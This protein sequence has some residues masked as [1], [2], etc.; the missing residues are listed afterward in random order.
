MSAAT[1]PQPPIHD[2]DEP[3]PLECPTC[4]TRHPWVWWEPDASRWPSLPAAMLR[5]RWTAPKVAPCSECTHSR[6]LDEEAELLERLKRAG[7]PRTLARYRFTGGRVRMQDGEDP[8]TFMR[9]VLGLTATIGILDV[10][11][12]AW[13]TLVGN[14]T[15]EYP[16]WRPSGLRWLALYGPVGT[17]KSLL[18]AGLA[19]RLM[20]LPP[21]QLVPL[22]GANFPSQ[23]AWDYAVS[24]GLD[25]TYTGTGDVG[26]RYVTVAEIVR[27]EELKWEGDRKPAYDAATC[28]CLLLDELG[29]EDRPSKHEQAVVERVLLYRYQHG[30]PVILTTNRGW[31]ELTGP[32][33]LYGRRVADRLSERVGPWALKITGPSWRRPPPERVEDEPEPQVA[34]DRKTAA[35]GGEQEALW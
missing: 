21:R 23:Q 31:D 29:T 11:R 13:R 27:Q 14:G 26:C 5:P 34:Q 16:G 19:R 32:D 33:P 20:T 4:H 18:L 7:V 8:G 24:R 3:P 28:G 9:R 1:L 2:G 25:S 12:E 10:N 30:L 6:G 35:A 22:E 15:S 17:G